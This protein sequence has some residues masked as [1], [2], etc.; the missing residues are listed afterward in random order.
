MDYKTIAYD[1][2]EAHIGVLTISRPERLN[3]INDRMIVEL[4]H[5]WSQRLYDLDTRVVILRGAGAKGF[6]G[7]LDVND[8][9]SSFDTMTGAE[10]YRFQMRITRLVASMRRAPQPIVCLVHGSAA[11]GGFSLALA[12][13]IRIITPD[14]RFNAAYINVGLGGADMSSS[15]FLPRL[16][17]SGRAYEFL[18]TGNFMNSDDAMNLGFASRCVPHEKLMETGMELA[19]TMVSKNPLGLRLTKEAINQNLDSGS[20]EHALHME[21]R[22]QALLFLDRALSEARRGW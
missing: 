10:I 20:L 2:P 7:G 18:L 4:D 8:S 9:L 22:N 12:S 14:S 15:Y 17:G 16:I 5:F 19:K 6:C 3:A 13:D 11:G 21:D 1:K